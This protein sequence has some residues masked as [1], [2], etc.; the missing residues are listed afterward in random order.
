VSDT[1]TTGG[2]GTV[3]WIGL[4]AMGAPMAG[5]LAVTFETLVWNR[6]AEVAADHARRYGS[7]AVDLVEAAGADVVLTCLPRTADVA[8]VARR[9]AGDLRPGTVWV[10][11]T[12]GEPEPSRLLAT[13]LDEHGVR[14]LD[15]PVSGGTSGAA[16][17]ALTTM[18][19]GDAETLE[20]VRPVLQTFSARIIHVG[21]TGA[22]HAVKAVNNTL[23]AANLWAAAEGLAAL[24]KAGVPAATALEVINTSSGRSFPSQELIPE[25]VLSREFPVTFALGLLAK[26]VGIAQGL[27]DDTAVPAPV[28]REVG[29]LLAVALRELGPDVDHVAAVQLVERW[30]GTELR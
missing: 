16:A 26:D 24:V 17:G 12:S 3:A 13:R 11:C 10:D 6:T 14:Y 1:A 4:G 15:A 30:S 7:R 21:P 29:A 2:R 27:L 25:R 5:H 18:V 23:L 19:G 22:G 20:L 28:L 8:D 9:L